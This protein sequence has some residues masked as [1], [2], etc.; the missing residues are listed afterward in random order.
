MR[1]AV[2]GSGHSEENPRLRI[3]LAG[4]GK[5]GRNYIRVLESIRNVRLTSVIDPDESAV[6]S[7][8]KLAGNVCSYR[9]FTSCVNQQNIDA[10]IIAAP[11][12]MHFDLCMKALNAGKHVL[13]EK[14]MTMNLESAVLMKDAATDRGLVLMVGHILQ[15]N[16]AFINL[17]RIHESGEIG[18]V[19]Y[20]YANRAGC[21]PVSESNQES[22]LW[23]LGPHDVS[24]ILKLSRQMPCRVRAGRADAYG[25]DSQCAVWAVLD[26]P[27]GSSAHLHLSRLESEKKRRFVVVGTNCVAEIDDARMPPS[28]K[29][30]SLPARIGRDEVFPEKPENKIKP[31][32]I[33]L[34]S[35]EPLLAQCEHFIN[36][37]KTGATPRSDADEGVNVVKVLDALQRSMDSD[38][39]F[40]NL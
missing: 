24:M 1:I 40:I 33:P 14:P 5:W 7:A 15:Y 9:N 31:V 30:F 25:S 21:A 16:P 27:D 10:V 28:L 8:L 37:I 29:I 22:T 38:G 3:A 11:S 32:E 12:D 34:E 39:Q 18:A 13:V 23:G 2:D 6:E 20:Y 26:F 19:N 36:C 17:R 4:A 35:V